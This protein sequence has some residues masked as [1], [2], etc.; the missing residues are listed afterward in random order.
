MNWRVE[1]I[2]AGEAITQ[3][4]LHPREARL[5]GLRAAGYNREEIV[6]LTGDTYRTVDRQLVRAQRKLRHARRAEAKV[7]STL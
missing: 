1:L 3:A 4:R 7:G 5:V 6:E 2:V